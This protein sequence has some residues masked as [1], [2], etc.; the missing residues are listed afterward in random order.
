MK[1]TTLRQITDI[2]D[3]TLRE[4]TAE[5]ELFEITLDQ[6]LEE[7]DG[8][9]FHIDVT[10]YE[11][12]IYRTLF[13]RKNWNET[14]KYGEFGSRMWTYNEKE[15]EDETKEEEVELTESEKQT[16]EDITNDNF[17][18]DGLDS[19]IWADCFMDT[20]TIGPRK[21][22]GVLSS[23]IK[24]GIINPI[25]KGRDGTISFTDAG[26]ELMIQLGYE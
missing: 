13:T 12:R 8:R 17:Y 22:R 10:E 23:L 18:E 1:K 20:T 26:K 25:A 4:L 24:K 21:C 14:K 3:A 2:E 15:T 6:L 11:G 7:A 19:I 9:R 5:A 16:L